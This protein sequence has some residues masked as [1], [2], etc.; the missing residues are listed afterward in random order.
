MKRICVLY[1]ISLMGLS[2]GMSQ[3]I[4]GTLVDSETNEPLVGVAV[5]VAGTPIGTVTDE[6]GYFTIHANTGK[7]AVKF[8]YLGYKEAEMPVFLHKNEKTDLGYIGL[9]E[10]GIQ[11]KDVIITS[12]MG[13]SRKTPIA[14][15][16]VVEGQI[17]ERLG[18]QEFP[19][20][21][22]STPGV[23]A[24][25]VGGGYGDSK[26]NM[27]GF[28]SAN[29][30]VMVNGVPVNDMEWGTLYWS[31]WA[32]LSDVTRTIQTQRGL[33][34]GKLSS[35]SVGGTVNIITKTT[36]QE[37]GGSVSYGVG[38]DGYNEITLSVS[39]GL[40]R[41]G[42]C[43]TFLGG[44]KWGDGYIQGTDF[45][46][47]NYFLAI[48]KQF[49]NSVLSLTAF[50]APQHHYQRNAN[51][52]LTIAEW[53]NV[54]NYMGDKSQYRYNP[55]YGFDQNGQR[56]TSSYNQ[57][58][59]PQI[60]LNYQWQINEK[61]SLSTSLYTSIGRGYGYSGQG[62]NYSYANSWYGASY[63]KLLYNFR[64]ADGTF[65]YDQVQALNEQNKTS[66]SDY[67]GSL[68]VMTKS[69]NNHNWYGLVSNYTNRV[70]DNWTV[71]GGIDMRYY[72]GTHTYVI[73]D[74][75]NGDYFVD[76]R[77]RS[78]VQA[79][80]NSKANDPN[81]VYEKL[82]VGDVIGRDYDNF[83]MQEGV[84]GQ[85]EYDSHKKLTAFVSGSLSNCSY[86]RYD[87]YYYDEEHARSKTKNYLGY[88][89][90]AGA[91]VNI[92]RYNNV[93]ANVGVISRAP[94]CA[95]AVFP[96]YLISNEINDNAINEKVVSLELGY[97]FRNRWL[98][99][100]VNAYYTKWL[101]RTMVKSG[102]YTNAEGLTDY[103]IANMSGVNAKH[104]GVEVD[105]TARPTKQLEVHG[106]LSLGNWKWDSNATAYFYNSEGQPLADLKGTLASGQGAAD[107][108]K[109]NLNQKGIH[110]GGSPQTT[111]SIGLR[112]KFENN[113]T[114]GADYYYYARNY[115]D[116]TFSGSSMSANGEF[117]L[118]EPWQLPDAGQVDLNANYRFKIG[119]CRAVLYGNV[120][121]VF[122]NEYLTEAYY[123]GT[124]NTRDDVYRCYYSFGRTYSIKLKLLF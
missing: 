21:L 72:K 101:D 64:N 91:N 32:G 17:E 2:K 54:K 25:K 26:L 57:Y 74:L 1:L 63:G 43:A 111:A 118:A 100:N 81:W 36:D 11:Y 13:L 95:G 105:L 49:S 46:G 50:G 30:A 61:S 24:S 7:G 108:A 39:T 104:M 92:D 44:K 66:D 14:M 82:G 3:Q 84:F 79:S 102:E 99:A 18:T 53:D 42:W 69:V 10:E 89:A 34:A 106:M 60:S 75:Y 120:Q 117:N 40:S 28:Q 15:S 8:S 116:Y 51:D 31:N 47:Y 70:A 93:F 88:S 38:N 87:R 48:S 109:F 107:H 121:N 33:G 124:K 23:Y 119:T 77:Y 52:G 80:R 67:N 73:T 68:M 62:Y 55:T 97:G 123:N 19:E 96:M 103:Y 90:K 112:Y 110:V 78:T 29:V 94:F 115:T 59:K 5:N 37:R 35:P 98:T 86:W 114:V 58:H 113:I 20:I 27:R 83:V 65:A 71:N 16:N 41:N 9:V 56:K 122:N 12:Q 22:K 6:S 45:E 4:V 76:Y 85:A